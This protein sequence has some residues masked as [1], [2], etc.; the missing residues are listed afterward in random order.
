MDA[1]LALRT[2]EE[3]ARAL[4]GR[5]D[6]LARAA[7]AE[8][9]A[10]AR[11]AERRERLIREG[12][13]AEAVGVAVG[14]VLQRLEVSLH[15]AAEARAAVEASRGEREQ[16]LLAV[17]GALRDLAREHDELVNSVHRDEMARTQQRMR[18]EQLEERALEELGLDADALVADYGPDQLVPLRRRGRRGRAEHARA[19][20]RTSA[21]SS[22][23]GC[24]P[25]SARCRCSAGSTRSRS[26]SSRRWRSATS[27]SPSSSR[28][29]RRPARTCS[30]S[31]ARSTPG[32]RRS[33]PRRT[34]T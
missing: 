13:A 8:R 29:S 28:T 1:R 27:S 19:D 3:R 7:Q 16:Q 31:S 24:A 4:H 30:T 6:P 5:A 20:A 17:R 22:R 32:S 10:R 12:R 2:A 21:R 26:R 25:P 23:S 9:E 15:R 33:S 14:V 34:P 18:I 11:A